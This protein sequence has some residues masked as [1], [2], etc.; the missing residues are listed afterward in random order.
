ME[1]VATLPT[2]PTWLRRTSRVLVWMMRVS[3]FIW[4]GL[5]ILLFILRF[6]DDHPHWVHRFFELI[7]A[8]FAAIGFCAS[9]YL[10]TLAKL[11]PSGQ[12]LWQKVFATLLLPACGCAVVYAM[13]MLSCAVYADPFR[14][15]MIA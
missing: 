15:L 14:G 10:W 7:M 1:A 5:T 4:V 2:V 3:L 8:T 6:V 12:P 13:S 11:W 9:A